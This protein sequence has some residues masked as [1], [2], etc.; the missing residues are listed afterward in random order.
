[1]SNH[2]PFD[3]RRHLHGNYSSTVRAIALLQD[4]V[5]A[6]RE[7][8]WRADLIT[9]LLNV[10]QETNINLSDADAWRSW[11][12]VV[13][14]ALPA[15][16]DS[17]LHHPLAIDELPDGFHPLVRDALFDGDVLSSNKAEWFKSD[18]DA[19]VQGR[20]G[21][22][23]ATASDL[24]DPPSA[25]K[26]KERAKSPHAAD[27]EGGASGSGGGSGPSVAQIL[28]GRKSPRAHGARPVAPRSEQA[29][30]QQQAIAAAL[31]AAKATI[32]AGRI[33]GEAQQQRP[34]VA[35]PAQPARPA[36]PAPH[37]EQQGQA[38]GVL[39]AE[40]L[41]S[42]RDLLEE[43][44]RASSASKAVSTEYADAISA[45]I[46]DE[47]PSLLDDELPEFVGHFRDVL[48]ERNLKYADKEVGR[49]ELIAGWTTLER[50]LGIDIAD[51]QRIALG[52]YVD[53]RDLRDYKPSSS[54][55]VGTN[56]YEWVVGSHDKKRSKNAAQLEPVEWPKFYDRWALAFK[57]VN[58]LVRTFAAEREHDVRR[59]RAFIIEELERP[60]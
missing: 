60:D 49:K 54:L 1:M 26:G 44:D 35:S 14:N 19:R 32:G 27:A 36:S 30:A 48:T 3:P 50:A 4:Y 15:V 12:N 7:E 18:D 57:A 42:L 52:Q 11:W 37:Q 40:F 13:I 33:S 9:E 28:G 45:V 47:Q 16:L 34:P 17:D 20:K 41:P 6:P 24:N 43:R 39:P 29:V 51:V 22:P 46:R 21:T 55:D 5:F 58:V 31:A 56:F 2:V 38:T 25:D 53:F 59:Y 8:D 10:P 23:R